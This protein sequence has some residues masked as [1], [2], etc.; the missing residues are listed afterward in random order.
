MPGDELL[1]LKAHQTWT[2]PLMVTLKSVRFGQRDPSW[3]SHFVAFWLWWR[4][5]RPGVCRFFLFC[6]RRLSLQMAD[7]F[8]R[9]FLFSSAQI[10]K[11]C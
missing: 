3:R 6:L 2:A 7:F 9:Q 11:G 1:P 10:D 8:L 5:V 4:V